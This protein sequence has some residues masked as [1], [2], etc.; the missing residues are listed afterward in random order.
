METSKKPPEE[1]DI[2]SK[3]DVKQLTLENAKEILSPEHLKVFE[4]MMKR[5]YAEGF[6]NGQKSMTTAIVVFL[7]TT[8]LF[9]QSSIVASGSSNITIG[10]VFPIM[11]TIQ[12]EKEVT[13]STPKFEIPIEKPKPIIKKKS[14][15]EKLIE[16]I[17]KL[18]NKNK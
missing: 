3:I 10:E 18:I 2:H 13:L 5:I 17:K 15:F 9:A 12:E 1:P 4:T 8:I 6:L 11:Q 16:F 14:F 7:F